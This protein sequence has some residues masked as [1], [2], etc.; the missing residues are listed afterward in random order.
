MWVFSQL[1]DRFDKDFVL[2]NSSTRFHSSLPLPTSEYYPFP[3]A[4]ADSA[5]SR[6]IAELSFNLI[7]FQFARLEFRWGSA[8]R[9]ISKAAFEH[10]LRM[11]K[12]YSGNE[13]NIP[14][15]TQIRN[16]RKVVDQVLNSDGGST[17]LEE[18]TREGNIIIFRDLREMM[19]RV[20]THQ[21]I[22]QDTKE[23]LGLSNSPHAR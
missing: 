16:H 5:V 19:K 7:F 17:I 9:P 21:A 11:M 23:N 15:T 6:L 1:L 2:V 3:G 12:M 20:S 4:G 14:S 8:N 18:R 13:F 10:D 22:N